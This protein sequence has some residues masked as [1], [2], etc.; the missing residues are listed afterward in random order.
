MDVAGASVD[1]PGAPVEVAGALERV[2][3]ASVDVA[4]A[5]VY[6]A[7]ALGLVSFRSPC[8]VHIKC[9]VPTERA[10]LLIWCACC[11]A[12]QL[13]PMEGA[14]LR[15]HLRRHREPCWVHP[16]LPGRDGEVLTLTAHWP[17]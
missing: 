12:L 5:S 1:V 6:V 9:G 11:L 13:A 16:E 14:Q 3:G 4:G 10:R 15:R 2:A 17:C 8:I 7:G